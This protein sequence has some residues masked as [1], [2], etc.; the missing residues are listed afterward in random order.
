MINQQQQST[1]AGI[2][3]SP[4]AARFENNKRSK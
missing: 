4:V 1:A 3:G 2:V